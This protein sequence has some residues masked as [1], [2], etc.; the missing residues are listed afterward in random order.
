[1]RNLGA[2]FLKRFNMQ[3]YPWL[4]Q[5]G[6]RLV[7]AAKILD[8]RKRGRRDATAF[9]SHPLPNEP[10]SKEPSGSSGSSGGV[11]EALRAT[12]VITTIKKTKSATKMTPEIIVSFCIRPPI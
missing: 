5:G 1:M 3:D 11:W 7:S 4:K 8:K 6:M 9:P 10:S 2:I 12:E